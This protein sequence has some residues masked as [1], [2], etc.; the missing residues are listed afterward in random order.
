MWA[1]VQNS[2]LTYYLICQKRKKRIKSLGHGK[3]GSE[4]P[5]TKSVSLPALKRVMPQIP[6][7]KTETI[8]ISP[9]QTLLQA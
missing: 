9:S 3:H 6:P 8:I 1:K 4:G 2:V 5:L 7:R